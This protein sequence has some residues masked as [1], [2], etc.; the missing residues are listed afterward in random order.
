MAGRRRDQRRPPRH[1]KPW[2]AA[3]R[4]SQRIGELGCGTS[5]QRKGRL[6][7]GSLLRLAHRRT[8][9]RGVRLSPGR[10][11]ALCYPREPPT[12]LP[13]ERA[14][15]ATCVGYAAELL[16]VNAGF[17]SLGLWRCC[18]RRSALLPFS[19]WQCYHRR[20][21]LLPYVF[22]IATDGSGAATLS[23]WSCCNLFGGAAAGEVSFIV[24]AGRSY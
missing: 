22:D 11:G 16:P 1:R 14:A 15:S 4:R 6:N 7:L 5:R 23:T 21:D 10:L 24:S 8:R 18:R 2:P 17:A 3:A 13:G 20:V 19:V 9:A 12:T